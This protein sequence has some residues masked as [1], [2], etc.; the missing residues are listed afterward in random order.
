MAEIEETLRIEVIGVCRHHCSQVWDETLNQTGVE[1]SFALRK[2]ENVYFP[3]VICASSST[4]SEVNPHS[5]EAEPKKDSSDK[6]LT[7]SNSLPKA[8]KQPRVKEK[9]AEVTKGVAPDAT[10]PPAASQDFTKDKEAPR[11]EIVLASL[12]ISIKG[13]P[14]GTNQGSSEAAISQ[15]KAPL[16][17]KIVIK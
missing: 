8:A 11:I 17:G 16:Q 12:P 13:D 1:A 2:A 9:D 14:N 15:S 7:S 4:D 5:K 6:V 3:P 10:K